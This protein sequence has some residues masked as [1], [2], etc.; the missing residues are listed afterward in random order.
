MPDNTDYEQ[1]LIDATNLHNSLRTAQMNMPKELSQR[2]AMSRLAGE[3]DR[4]CR[5]VEDNIENW[6][7]EQK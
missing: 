3:L 7:K 5:Y 1:L 4:W 6:R 2:S